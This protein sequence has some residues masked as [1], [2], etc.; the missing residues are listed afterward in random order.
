MSDKKGRGSNMNFLQQANELYD[1]SV[2]VRRY[3]HENPEPSSFETNTVAFI[4]AELTKLGVACRSIP[5][6]GVLGV[7]RG[8][9]PGK[10][11]LLR[12]DCD[13]LRIQEAAEN[14][15]APKVCVSKRAGLAHCCG[16][17]MHTAMLLTAARLLQKERDTLKGTVLLLFERGE[18]G[19]GNVY[20]VHRYLQ[21]EGLG[22][23]A[24]FSQHNDPL[25]PAGRIA[26][27]PGPRFA[28]SFVFE[29]K[30][31]GK[32]GH[33]SRPDRCSNPIDCFLAIAA[34]YKDLRMRLVA[35]DV[36]FTASINSVS[37]GTAPNITP[38]E[39]VF[40]GTART[41][42]LESGLRFREQ[43]ERI[44]RMNCELFGCTFETPLWKGPTLPVINQK[45]VSVYARAVTERLIGE[46]NTEDT[47]PDLCGE[48]FGVTTAFYPSVM[49]AI[50]TG[51]AA[52]GRAR[53][54]H[55]PRYDPEEKALPLGSAYYAA[56]AYF[57][58]DNAPEIDFR[59]FAGDID[60]LFALTNRPIP[61]HRDAERG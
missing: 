20:Y 54:L 15:L 11:V 24:C 28:G 61:P 9:L 39:L 10:T 7:I 58:S 8:A 36:L 33:G 31:R 46:E 52:E 43:F 60:A 18:E 25:L 1:Y 45:D 40:S 41:Y 44:I 32:G 22:I 29:V 13:A 37:A 35:P 4:C 2:S 3:L 6:G 23:D 17:D 27:S 38:E 30:L 19:G 50:G 21:A 56:C 59:P 5:D 47:T 26:V 57:Y 48:T 55:D 14:D 53:P 16:H 51:N 49:A 34:A 42:D 12:A